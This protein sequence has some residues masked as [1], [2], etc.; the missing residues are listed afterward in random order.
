LRKN[1]GNNE[2]FL[3]WAADKD[4]LIYDL[5]DHDAEAMKEFKHRLAEG[6]HASQQPMKKTFGLK[7]Y[8]YFYESVKEYLSND[9]KISAGNIDYG[10]WETSFEAIILAIV[11]LPRDNFVLDIELVEGLAYEADLL[12]GGVLDVNTWEQFLDWSK[13]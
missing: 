1:D 5:I 8:L 3:H 10:Q 13:N 7:E 11:K 6:Y 9:L 2:L 4:N 12:E